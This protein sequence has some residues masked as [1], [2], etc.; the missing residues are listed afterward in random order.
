MKKI[1]LSILVASITIFGCKTETT[2]NEA[3][4][5]TTTPTLGHTNLDVAGFKDKMSTGKYVI[6][7]V[8]TA[9][10]FEAGHIDGAINF[11]VQKPSFS[12]KIVKMNEEVDYLVYCLSGG[13][14]VT[15]CQIM[16]K[17]GLKNLYNLEGGFMAWSKEN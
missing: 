12:D 7:D 14:S 9:E 4:N 11:D 16:S 10:E 2:H 15:A 3:T 8:R 17:A 6:I 1:F 5:S 13:R